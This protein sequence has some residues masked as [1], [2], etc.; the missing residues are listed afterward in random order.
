M[1][2]NRQFS[3]GAALTV[4]FTLACNGSSSSP[5]SAT[6]E[7]GSGT[8]S[9]LGQ[10]VGTLHGQP[11][12]GARVEVGGAV[13]STD[14]SGQF[15]L[16][17][18]GGG[19]LPIAI[20]VRASDHVTRRSFVL[21]GGP[22]LLVDIIEP[23]PLWNLQFY[24]ELCRDGAGGGSLKA[25]NPWTVEPRFYV[26]RR[27]E[28]GQNRPIPDA[29]VDSVVE[30]IRTVLPLLTGGRL[31]GNQIEGGTEPPADHTPGTVVIRWDPVEVSRAAGAAAGITRGVGGNASVVVLRTIEDTEVIFHELG[32]VM[33][34]YHPLG[35]LRPSLMFGAG[36]PERPHFT[37]WDVLHANVLYARPPGNTDVD[38]DPVGFL[39][40]AATGLSALETSPTLMICHR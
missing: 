24:R 22:S 39:L 21:P 29:A 4:L 5:S 8:L 17:G 30:A 12:A 40:N 7:T 19:S 10:I 31:R 11:V 36:R 3:I 1:K 16:S 38:N 6:V 13:A 23:D 28:S 32:H 15:Q 20:S 25:L 34:L 14:S 9:L 37:D 26:D 33:G 18:S 2:W 35:G 27:P